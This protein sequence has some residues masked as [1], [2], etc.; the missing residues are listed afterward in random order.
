ML[1]VQM[2]NKEAGVSIGHR[3]WLKLKQGNGMVGCAHL[4]EVP[5]DQERGCLVE[6]LPRHL[7]EKMERMCEKRKAS[8]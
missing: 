7:V 8:Q 5:L 3:K 1:E 4:M 6:T 2:P